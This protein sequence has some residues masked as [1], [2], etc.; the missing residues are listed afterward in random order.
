MKLIYLSPTNMSTTEAGAREKQKREEMLNHMVSPGVEICIL[1][2]PEG[3]LAIETMQDE[4]NGIPG[5]LKALSRVESQYDGV[6]TGCFGEPGLDAVRELLHIPAVGCCGPAIHW[7]NQLGK[8]F[9]V[10]SPVKS[11]VPFTIELVEKYGLG[12]HLAS[13]RPLDIPVLDIRSDRARA[14]N[15]ATE[16]ARGVLSNDGA[17]AL[18]LGCMSL[19]FQNIA[20]DMSRSL[21]VPVINPLHA[22]LH[23]LEFL[24]GN[25]LNPSPLVYKL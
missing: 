8:R 10:L 22:S 7:A 20:G 11:A 19:A 3:P 2:N 6:L 23:A 21:G 24:V 25:G 12:T 4:Y 18:V 16:V 5:M 14:L 15:K 17:D 1:D 13:V 9:S